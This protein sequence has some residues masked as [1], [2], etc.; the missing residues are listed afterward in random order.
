MAGDVKATVAALQAQLRSL[1][2]PLQLDAG[3]AEA[4]SPAP[5]L[6]ALSW[7]LL[8]FSKHVALLVTQQG[9]QVCLRGLGNVAVYA[10][11]AGR[12]PVQLPCHLQ[13]HARLHTHP[14]MLLQLR[15]ASDLRF[16]EGALRFA[17]DTLALRP[18]LSA[19][20]LLADGQFARAKAAFVL[21]VAR[22]CKERHNAA[23]R[24]ERLA[25]LKA[26]HAEQ[27]LYGA[28]AAAAASSEQQQQQQQAGRLGERSASSGIPHPPPPHVR[29]VS[30]AAQQQQAKAAA[31]MGCIDPKVEEELGSEGS[32]GGV[33]PDAGTTPTSVVAS[34]AA[35]EQPKQAAV[36]N[37]QHQACQ[38]IAVAQ[39]P[40]ASPADQPRALPPALLAA[41]PAEP[42]PAGT[43]VAT[44]SAGSAQACALPL[45]SYP[46]LLAAGPGAHLPTRLPP[47]HASEA[48]MP[49]AA[50]AVL[51]P[52]QRVHLQAA[53][54][55]QPS[56]MSVVAVPSTASACASSS[57]AD[58]QTRRLIED[59]QLRLA[60]A[61][62]AAASA[63]WAVYPRGR[64]GGCGAV[65]CVSSWNMCRL[66]CRHA[67]ASCWCCAIYGWII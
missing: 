20:Q 10:T 51:S 47:G 50:S 23:A 42:P 1:K 32:D 35:G 7:L 63:R 52:Q 13:H 56:S 61:E 8:H 58:Q 67:D 65:Q 31:S 17:R 28:A 16:V 39:R 18:A 15:G 57:L 62:E 38:P 55:A 33:A 26:C 24:Q 41:R 45:L 44:A 34:A 64:E 43:L 27:R 5:V 49:P 3:A 30:T 21:D 22:A 46:Q 19:V 40:D 36:P 66:T 48:A 11:Q 25:A 6:Q 14:P 2:C 60:L 12:D 59:L 29:V 54:A 37:Q 9:L 53:P 4:G